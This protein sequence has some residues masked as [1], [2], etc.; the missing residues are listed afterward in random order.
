MKTEGGIKVSGIF[1]KFSRSGFLGLLTAIS[2]VALAAGCGDICPDGTRPVKKRTTIEKGCS[3]SSEIDPLSGRPKTGVECHAEIVTVYVCERDPKPDPEP[4]PGD[5]SGDE[6]DGDHGS[7]QEQALSLP[8]TLDWLRSLSWHVLDRDL[9]VRPEDVRIRLSGAPSRDRLEGAS[10]RWVLRDDSGFERWVG[11]L[12]LR[13]L[14]SGD[15]GAVLVP[16]EGEDFQRTVR[17]AA[18]IVAADP[19][20]H[21]D[22]EWRVVLPPAESEEQLERDI[23]MVDDLE[24]SI[25]GWTP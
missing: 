1:V 7:G 12:P 22:R 16:V 10:F 9:L 14:E 19:G 24:L 3:G 15:H 17:E 4:D 8:E 13:I 5:G 25:L 2:L 23:R 21:G 18:A 6:G 20:L 11:Q